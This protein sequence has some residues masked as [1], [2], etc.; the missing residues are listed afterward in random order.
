MAADSECKI[1]Q[2]LAWSVGIIR[3][4]PERHSTIDNL[5]VEADSDMYDNKVSKRAANG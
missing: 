2:Q 3:F 1:R 4:D 5:L